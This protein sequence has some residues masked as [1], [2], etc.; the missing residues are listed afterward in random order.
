M[1]PQSISHSRWN[2]GQAM[3]EY[4][5]LI[6]AAIMIAIAAGLFTGFIT[7]SLHRTID[8][9]SGGLCEV[10]TDRPESF[11]GSTVAHLGE[12]TIELT[13]R[14][15][16]PDDNT[17]TVVYRVTSVDQHH[18]S[19]WNLGLPPAVANNLIQVSAGEKIEWMA[20]GDPSVPAAYRWP[21]LK[22]DTGYGEGGNFS[23]D[24]A[25]VN[26]NAN[27][28]AVDNEDSGSPAN[29]GGG[30]AG[31]NPGGGN[32]GNNP[33]GGNNPN[34]KALVTFSFATS[35]ELKAAL[36][37]TMDTVSRDIVLLF[38]GN[39][40]W[41]DSYVVVKAG[42]EE[43]QSVISVPTMPVQVTDNQDC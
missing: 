35:A 36:S 22:F 5:V 41:S 10:E 3:S 16:N 38:S 27:E 23:D 12:H 8:G 30:N 34:N 20:S 9:L 42:Q 31:N 33:G 40:D 14:V 6:P 2:T 39:Y 32:A 25:D 4:M 11:S 21:G 37:S 1:N 19:H 15:Y 18:I 29:P 24:L 28:N 43:H 17:T 26:L 7:G 13:S